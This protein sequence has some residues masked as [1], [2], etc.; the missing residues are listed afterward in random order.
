MNDSKSAVVRQVIAALGEALASASLSTFPDAECA[1]LSHTADAARY[2]ACPALAGIFSN[3]ASVLARTYSV[4]MGVSVEVMGFT[5]PDSAPVPG[6]V[7]P[8]A[9]A[10]TP[11]ADD[12]LPF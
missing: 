8:P 6:P 2:A 9:A 3:A 12:G 7:P 5:A 10:P 1:V 11:P 4:P